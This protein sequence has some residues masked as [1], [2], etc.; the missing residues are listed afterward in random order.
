M[1]DAGRFH[2][3]IVGGPEFLKQQILVAFPGGVPGPSA[4]TLV[5]ESGDAKARQPVTSRIAN[6]VREWSLAWF[7]WQRLGALAPLRQLW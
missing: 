5:Q 6:L 3:L 2:L 1:S 4:M 7:G